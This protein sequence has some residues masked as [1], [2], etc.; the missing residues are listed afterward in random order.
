M[1]ITRQRR[2]GEPL[3]SVQCL[4]RR[5]STAA[6]SRRNLNRRWIVS[7]PANLALL[8]YAR[9]M[10]KQSVEELFKNEDE[11]EKGRG[12]RGRPI[13]RSIWTWKWEMVWKREEGRE[14]NGRGINK[15]RT[16]ETSLQSLALARPF[17]SKKDGGNE[18][19]DECI[20]IRDNTSIVPRRKVE[21]NWAPFHLSKFIYPHEGK[22]LRCLQNRDYWTRWILRGMGY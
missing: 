19:F 7:S 18:I 9:T 5:T 4:I 2:E 22:C 12:V 16:H 3:Q 14:G 11:R 21:T 15:V 6:C 8:R 1:Q 10:R 17:V 20:K 13:W